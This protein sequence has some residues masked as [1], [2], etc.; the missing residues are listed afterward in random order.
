MKIAKKAVAVVVHSCDRYQLLYKGF[1]F[2]F[3][4][5]W[6]LHSAISNFYFLTEE[7][8]FNSD[9]FINIK[10]GKGEWSDRL[11]KGLHLLEEK[12]ILYLQEDM[13]FTKSL[14]T[15]VLDA[16]AS[17]TIENYVKLFKL[18]S[19]EVFVTVPTEDFIAGLGVAVLNNRES[20]FLMSHQ[21]S[22]WNKDF[23][24]S[25][26]KANEH[27]WRNERKGTKRLKKL[28]EIIYHIDL[29]SENGKPPINKNTNLSNQSAYKT[30]SANAMLNSSIVF[31]IEELKQSTK[32]ELIKY[33]DQLEYNFQK[34]LTHDGK[35]VPRKDDI[36]KKIKKLFRSR[37]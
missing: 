20:D 27:P 11:R 34:R 10:T 25:Q 28:D 12:Y 7:A 32:E 29:L 8:D 13:W 31:F 1:E 3:K 17:F 21:P 36:F 35:P 26:L 2:F 4:K 23:L 6:P 24:I 19:S 18:N 30:I 37:R 15:E 14:S 9:L 5:H 16:I 22:M 33:S